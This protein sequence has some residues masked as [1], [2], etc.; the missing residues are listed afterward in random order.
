MF[1]HGY[2]PVRPLA[3]TL[4]GIPDLPQSPRA[5]EYVPSFGVLH[6]LVLQPLERLVVEILVAQAL[7]RGKLDKGGFHVVYPSWG[8]FG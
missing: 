4:V 7:K 5:L 1:D 6:Q 8:C 3:A 2:L